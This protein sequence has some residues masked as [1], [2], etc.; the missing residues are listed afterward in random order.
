MPLAANRPSIDDEGVFLHRHSAEAA[1]WHASMQ[2]QRPIPVMHVP[3]ERFTATAGVPDRHIQTPHL[4]GNAWK[5][6]PKLPEPNACHRK[7]RNCDF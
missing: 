4:I 3:A 6:L 2:W 1:E 7:F 5:S